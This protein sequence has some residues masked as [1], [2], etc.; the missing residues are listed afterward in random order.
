MEKEKEQEEIH[1]VEKSDTNNSN[2]L[3]INNTMLAVV[4]VLIVMSAVQVFQLQGLVG[5]ISSGAIKASAQ[6]SGGSA[7]GLPSQVGGCG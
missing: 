2:K 4:S 7:I 1:I 5:A 6:T 3:N